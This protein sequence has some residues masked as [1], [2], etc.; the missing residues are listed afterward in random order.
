MTDPNQVFT[1]FAAKVA[2]EFPALAN[3][4]EQ[5]KNGELSEQDAMRCLSE[6][7]MGD[8]EL[9]ARFQQVAMQALAPLREDQVAKPL[10]HNGIIMHK[11]RGLPRLNPLVEGALIERAQFDGDMPELRTGQLPEGVKPAVSVDTDVRSPVAMGAMLKDASEQVAGKI[12][13]VEPERV[14]LIEAIADNDTLALVKATGLEA[15]EARD[16]VLDGKS[17]ALDI[18]E[19][20]R[21][22]VPAPVKVTKPSGAA[23]L[24]MSP[25]ERRQSA[26]SFL[27]TTQG[28]RS[29]VRGI[30]EMVEGRLA[31]AGFDVTSRPFDKT[32]TS[33]VLAAHK[34]EVGIDGP[35]ATQSAFN[36]ID[37]AAI[38]IAANLVRDMGDRRGSVILEVVP[39][40]TV[41]IRSVGWAGR[42][43]GTDHL[44]AG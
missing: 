16:L 38:S 7:V 31:A 9:A 22:Q 36:M 35:N 1:Q 41:D 15:S 30:K 44:L 11:P 18:P 21:G 3:I 24:A 5:A 37:V 26:W 20:R 14:K 19:Y 23:L 33:P 28:R 43:M 2:D 40:N 32:D 39:I 25:A 29:A 42:L 17:N 6:T 10:D 4:L 13:D 27:S 8:P 34:W 12:A